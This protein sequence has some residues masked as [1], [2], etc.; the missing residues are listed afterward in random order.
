MPSGKLIKHQLPNEELEFIRAR[1][2]PNPIPYG[3]VTG[4]GKFI[5]QL[6][7]LTSIKPKLLIRFIMNK[8]C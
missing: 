3:L 5:P 2:F 1:D 6:I 7:E 8:P 4:V